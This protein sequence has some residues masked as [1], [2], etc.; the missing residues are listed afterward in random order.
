M[1]IEID[2]TNCP[3]SHIEILKRWCSVSR[4]L[5]HAS[6]VIEELLPEGEI[7]TEHGMAIDELDEIN[8]A[9]DWLHKTFRNS[10]N[11]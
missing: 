4:T 8:A 9:L 10:L 1:I 5:H 7:K 6:S 11:K 3:Q 2:F